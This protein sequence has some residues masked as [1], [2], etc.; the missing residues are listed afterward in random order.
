MKTHTL[1]GSDRAEIFLFVLKAGMKKGPFLR[2]ICSQIFFID[3]LFLYSCK[4]DGAKSSVKCA[5]M[6]EFCIVVNVQFS[7]LERYLFPS[8]K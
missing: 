1:S 2:L 5:G 6:L 3:V 8:R 7:K 4:L